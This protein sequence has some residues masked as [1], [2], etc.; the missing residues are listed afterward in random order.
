MTDSPAFVTNSRCAKSRTV[1]DS[2]ALT[3]ISP[4]P[5]AQNLGTPLTPDGRRLYKL[6]SPFYPSSGGADSRDTPD[7]KEKAVPKKLDMSRRLLLQKQLG[8]GHPDDKPTVSRLGGLHSLGLLG[9]RKV[10][11]RHIRSL[12][13]MIREKGKR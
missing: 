10:P 12:M 6:P 9:F 7:G 4:V 5:A 3:R 11:F 13:D 2:I 1:H 8:A